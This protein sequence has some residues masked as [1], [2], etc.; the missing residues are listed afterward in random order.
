MPAKML[1]ALSSILL[2]VMLITS[3]WPVKPE[4][5]EETLLTC[6]EPTEPEL[7]SLGEFRVTAYC[8]CEKCCGKW[9]QNRPNGKV[10]GST[11]VELV[12]NYSIAVDPTI[13]PY[14]TK[15]FIDGKEYRADDT[16]GAIKANRID[17]YMNSHDAA[18]EWGV[19]YHEIFIK[20]DEY[21]RTRENL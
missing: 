19:Q 18:L 2:V 12:S 8:S 7:I 6:V 13:I 3:F 11:G 4:A 17:L 14:G 10:Y 9:A 5:K 20:G 21:Y 15:I 16:G 1:M